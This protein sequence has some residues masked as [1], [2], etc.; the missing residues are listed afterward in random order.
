MPERVAA[1]PGSENASRRAATSSER[2]SAAAGVS[3]LEGARVGPPGSLTWTLMGPLR[4]A[5]ADAGAGRGGFDA[6]WWPPSSMSPKMSSEVSSSSA[7]SGGVVTAGLSLPLPELIGVNRRTATLF[8]DD[9]PW[10]ED[11]QA[12]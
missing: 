6:A 11:S 1:S 7:G 8:E 4:P 9:G 3:A 2:A 12:G 10:T 5:S